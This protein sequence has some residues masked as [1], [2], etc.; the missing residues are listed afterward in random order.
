MNELNST[1]L[2]G[3]RTER[4]RYTVPSDNGLDHLHRLLDFR[5]L[6]L[7][8]LFIYSGLFQRIEF[9]QTSIVV[10]TPCSQGVFFLSSGTEIHHDHSTRPS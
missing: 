1:G 2:A 3:K 5:R 7:F 6:K 9:E 10:A 4:N 8:S